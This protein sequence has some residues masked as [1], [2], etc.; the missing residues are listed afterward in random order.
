L[1]GTPAPTPAPATGPS[2]APAPAPTP[3]TPPTTI[4]SV[5]AAGGQAIEAGVQRALSSI[6]THE[7]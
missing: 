4:G 2:T 1:T 6:V 7:A 3:A 5:I